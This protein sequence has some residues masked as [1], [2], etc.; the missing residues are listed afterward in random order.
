MAHWIHEQGIG[1]ER[2]ALIDQGRIVAAHIIGEDRALAAGAIVKGQ[3]TRIAPGRAH[4]RLEGG[5]SAIL[6]PL[7]AGVTEG[8]HLAVEI[9]RQEMHERGA[10]GSRTKPVRVRAAAQRLAPR[11][12]PS[13]L[14]Q[15]KAD[16]REIITSRNPADDQLA[17]AGWHE[18]MAEAESGHIGFSGGSLII[19]P[20]PAMTLIDVDGDS[21]PLPLALAAAEAAAH[22]MIRLGITGSVGIDFPT[23]ARKADRTAVLGRFDSA[24]S[25]PCE[26]T[27]INGFGFMQLV[28]RRIR[29]SLVEYAQGDPHRFG[30]MQLLR[31]AERTAGH[32]SLR[33]IVSNAAAALLSAHPGWIETLQQRTARPVE[34][35]ARNGLDPAGFAVE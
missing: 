2:A 8:A 7:P 33:L 18:V 26:R 17:K 5:E 13:L 23:L 9:V 19:S 11:P 16:G 28:S 14:E 4:M 25:A 3:L 35:H 12:A 22:A 1:E 31:R 21:A 6:H 29:P 24:M 10:G 27:A 30:L 34:I 20:T 15:L 32:G